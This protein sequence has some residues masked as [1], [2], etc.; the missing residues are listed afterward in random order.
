MFRAFDWILRGVGLIAVA[1]AAFAI[2]IFWR[3]G[4]DRP[5]FP[6]I[7]GWGGL[8]R[9]QKYEVLWELKE[10]AA[11]NGDYTA[12]TCMQLEKFDPSSP[13]RWVAGPEASELYAKARDIAATWPGTSPRQA[14]IDDVNSAGVR[15]FVWRIEMEGRNIGG[16]N[17]LLYEEVTK[18]LLSFGYQ[19]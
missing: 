8:D 15:M 1:L 16:M 4:A 2:A 6:E 18:R 17:I 3:P 11:P 19:V 5:A 9:N 12:I 7:F 14:C 13:D 10:P